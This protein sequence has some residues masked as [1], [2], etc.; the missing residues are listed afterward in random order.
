LYPLGGIAREPGRA[1]DL[2]VQPQ[3][4]KRAAKNFF[5][6][7]LKG[8][9]YVP[10]VTVTDKLKSYGAARREILPVWNIGSIGV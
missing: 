3:P 1:L 7:L 10:R 2:P 5:R 4:D 8:L 9:T 6:K